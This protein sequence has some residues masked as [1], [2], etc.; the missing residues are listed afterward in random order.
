MYNM[1]QNEVEMVIAGEG[2]QPSLNGG[3]RGPHA[4]LTPCPLD[5]LVCPL[6]IARAGP[7]L[8]PHP[9]PLRHQGYDS[10][11]EWPTLSLR[12]SQGDR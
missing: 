10:Q 7:A 6:H 12:C 5:S 9:V 2:S 3:S 4:L 1:Q 8:P 11:Q